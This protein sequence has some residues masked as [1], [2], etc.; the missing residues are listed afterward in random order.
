[1]PFKPAIS[2]IRHVVQCLLIVAG[3]IA[4]SGC[5]AH[6]TLNKKL[7]TT[8]GASSLK[9][10]LASRERSDR[11]IL[12]LAF[13]GGGTRA[14]A[15][16][17]GV[18]E[19][20]SRIELPDSTEGKE[21]KQ[22]SKK[23]TLLDEV[24]LISSVSAGSFTAAYYGLHGD[25]IFKDFRSR[26]LIQN[27]QRILVQDVAN[28][29]NWPK[30]MSPRFGRSDLA[31]EYFD[32]V[33]FKNA[34]FGDLSKGK[35]PA[36]L[37][38]AT[39]A[40][41]GLSFSFTPGQFDLICSDYSSFP[42]S[43]AVAASGAVPGIFSPII[44]RNYAGQCGSSAPRWVTQA[45]L[46]PDLTS[47]VYHMAVNV[48]A[49]LD[50]KTHPYIHLVDGGVSDN[51][52]LRGLIDSVT[53]RGGIRDALKDAG[54][55][56]T[57]R[58]AFVIVDAA[59]KEKPQWRL[60]GDIPGLGDIIG[61]SSTI[62]INK[63]NFETIDLL[64]RYIGEWYEEDVDA[65]RKPID[66]YIIHVAFDYLPVQEE[67]DYFNDIPTNLNLSEKQVDKLRDVAHRL[68]YSSQPFVKLVKDMGGKFPDK[69]RTAG[70][71]K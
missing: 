15:L 22:T 49:Y 34:T 13:S 50:S 24:D 14:A 31:Q 12:V 59:R 69:S 53:V 41:D 19:A 68:L 26:F 70:A 66:F 5:T 47:R 36:I 64:R 7:E 52:G 6:Y 63:Y 40:V 10:K 33:L 28:P 48:N 3:L 16:S 38:L 1:M 57:R 44:L 54:L 46:K 71:A 27:H 21:A 17:Y 39:D 25:D 9:N 61:L 11:L 4:L 8:P 62:M 55:G 42:V 29:F 30:L 67:R 58:I 2:K 23:H 51:L 56:K 35:G 65:G 60:G 32:S 37:I 45:L 18:L 20:M 43:R